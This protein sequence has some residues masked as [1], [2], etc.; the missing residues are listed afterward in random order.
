LQTAFIK[1][2]FPKEIHLRIF[3]RFVAHVTRPL[4]TWGFVIFVLVREKLKVADTRGVLDMLCNSASEA[5][6]RDVKKLLY[7]FDRLD[8]SEKQLMTT[9]WKNV[10]GE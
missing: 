6:F 8:I 9:G 3:D 10:I 5:E 2:E 4:F 7:R 1:I